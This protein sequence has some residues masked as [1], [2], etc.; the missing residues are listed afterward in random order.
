MVLVVAVFITAVAGELSAQE[1]SNVARHAA[2]AAVRRVV[3]LTD[4]PPLD[5]Q[6]GSGPPR[7]RSDPDDIQ[8][9]VRFLLYANEFEI[10]GLVASS[11][12]FANIATKQHLLDILD[13]Y[14]DVQG[15]LQKHDPRFPTAEYLRSITWQGASGSY[16]KPAA[17]IIGEGRDSEASEKIVEIL[18]ERDAR[19]VWFCVWGGSCDLAQALWEIKETHSPAEADLLV[20]KARVYLITLQDGSG[21]WLLDTFPKLF[22]IA[23]KN[24]WTGIFG[25][26]DLTWLNANVRREH[27]VLGA[28]YPTMGMGTKPGIKEG[29]SPSY[30]ILVSAM[31][32]L[33]NPDAPSEAS[34]GGRFV[35]VS[36]GSNHWTDSPHGA[37]TVRRWSTSFDNDFAAR[38]DWCVHEFRDANHAPLVDV[39]G[40]PTRQVKP[41]E[42]IKLEGAATDPDGDSLSCQWWQ[43]STN[44]SADPEVEIS[45]S[46]SIDQASFV[47][48]NQP[49]QQIHL[50]LEVTDNGSPALVGYQH[51]LFNIE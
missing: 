3:I 39:I 22:V 12:T 38:M 15:N 32:G 24:T 14:E 51:V 8:S 40:S 18:E 27:G 6:I 33:N 9:M 30:L 43:E 44:G 35:P 47:V 1:S 34:W 20:S 4:F 37:D 45:S 10:E 11:A 36:P 46:D 5:V 49:G 25:S 17:Q 21:Q 48:P 23:A 41:G 7:K 26:S 28:I 42:R 2:E 13:L 16:G 19:P 50:I 29:D 31:H